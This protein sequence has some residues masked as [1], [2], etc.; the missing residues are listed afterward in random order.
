MARLLLLDH[1]RQ[2]HSRQQG[3]HPTTNEG[4]SRQVSLGMQWPQYQASHDNPLCAAAY[5]VLWLVRCGCCAW[6]HLLHV[7]HMYCL[8]IGCAMFCSFHK[9]SR[10]LQLASRKRTCMAPARHGH[11]LLRFSSVLVSNLLLIGMVMMWQLPAFCH[12]V[13]RLRQLHGR[14]GASAGCGSSSAGAAAGACPGFC[15]AV[16]LADSI[17][18]PQHALLHA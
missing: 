2:L 11:L 9:P 8:S 7:L 12:A 6:K 4:M 17:A 1:L 3:S 13:H 18:S 16:S 15:Q 5:S 14:E 10:V